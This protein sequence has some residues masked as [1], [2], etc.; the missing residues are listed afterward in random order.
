MRQTIRKT[1]APLLGKRA[2]S[3]AAQATAI[4][5]D[6]D[7]A[8]YLTAYR[9]LA[10][11]GEDPVLHYIREGWREGRDPSPMFSTAFYLERN[12]TSAWRA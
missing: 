4:R 3:L 5:P 9:D 7:T 2:P 1:L 12:P 6:F 10:P 8:F 11:E